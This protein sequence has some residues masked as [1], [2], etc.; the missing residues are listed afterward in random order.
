MPSETLHRMAATEATKPLQTK[1]HGL[2]S[3]L[4]TLQHVTRRGRQKP[5]AAV[6]T[7]IAD[8][9]RVRATLQE[10]TS[11][12]PL[13]VAETAVVQRIHHALD[14]IERDAGLLMV[15]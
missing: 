10:A 11:Q 7:L 2:R 4:V 5:R 15:N 13:E 6:A 12:L 1:I 14:D 9:A 3:R 8:A